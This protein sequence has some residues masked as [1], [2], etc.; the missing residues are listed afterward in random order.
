MFTIDQRL[1]CGFAAGSSQESNPTDRA[2]YND[3]DA[4]SD[5]HPGIHH[6]P[7]LVEHPELVARLALATRGVPFDVAFSLESHE[8]IAWNII[9]GQLDG[10]V[11]DWRAMNWKKDT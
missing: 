2:D 11:W 7:K 1:G 8:I 3:S 5:H 10:R 4:P 6:E 9:L